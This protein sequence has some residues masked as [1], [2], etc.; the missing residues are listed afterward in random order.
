MNVPGKW[1]SSDSAGGLGASRDGN[2]RDHVEGEGWRERIWGKIACIGGH[3][4]RLLWKSS[5]V[6]TTRITLV[7]IPSNGGY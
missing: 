5:V 6:E 1:I 4:K 3:L 7:K 2:R